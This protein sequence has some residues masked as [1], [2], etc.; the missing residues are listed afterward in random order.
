LAVTKLPYFV[1]A[2]AG[3][4]LLELLLVL[5]VIAIGSATISLNLRGSAQT[6][7][8]SEAERLIAVLEATRAEARASNTTMRWHVINKGFEVRTLPPTKNVLM[9][10]TWLDESI[11]AAPTDILFS[12]E[13]VQTRTSITLLHNSGASLKIGSDGAAAFKVLP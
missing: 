2:A 10:M 13:P 11:D 4:T 8:R 1:R 7:L 12:A 6:Q 9:T 5:A 3:F